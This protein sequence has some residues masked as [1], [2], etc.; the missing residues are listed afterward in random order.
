MGV[1][2][3]RFDTRRKNEF[4]DIPADQL[5]QV[6]V[7]RVA[8][9]LTFLVERTE[10]ASDGE[11]TTRTLEIT[12]PPTRRKVTGIEMQLGPVEAIRKDSP[13]SAAGF[14]VGDI[15][16]S[17]NG[18]AVGNPL[19]LSMR[20]G[21]W[22][23]QEVKVQVVR[24]VD[25][26]STTVDLTVRPDGRQRYLQIFTPGSLVGIEPIGIAVS[27]SNK[28]AA[29]EEGS[30]AALAGLQPGDVVYKAQLVAESDEAKEAVKD[31]L[32]KRYGDEIEI[33]D[34]KE[35]WPYVA[36]LVQMIPP[37]VALKLFYKRGVQEMNSSLT[38]VDS[39]AWYYDSRGLILTPLF[40]VHTAASWGEAW[41]LGFRATKEGLFRVA[42]FLGKLVT[43]Q[44]SPKTLGGP[45]MIAAVAGSEASEGIPRLLLFL[46]LLSA[47]LAILNFLPIPA[48]DG[49]HIVFLIAEAVTGK[50]V[51]ERLQGTLTLIGVAC[52]LTLMLFVFGNDI[53]RIFL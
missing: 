34:M 24:T 12:V 9:P 53:S 26:E 37:G 31:V 7:N 19:L 45:L 16:K 38:L 1:D 32:G 3:Q 40:R 50:P 42:D 29:I 47:N 28:I 30:P 52:L 33:D 46:T 25:D 49:G 36:D 2:G 14:Q 23:D 10:K 41:K 6:L 20:F 8:E 4:G 22:T 43:F 15:L 44:V 11:A 35:N 18:D 17:I 21:Q 48:L 5:Q 51:D 39:G 13:A 27:V